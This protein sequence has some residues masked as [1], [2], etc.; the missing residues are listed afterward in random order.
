MLMTSTF[1]PVSFWLLNLKWSGLQVSSIRAS[2]SDDKRLSIFTGTKTLHLRCLSR[3]DR[4]A[5]IEALLAAKDL[6]PRVL[7]SNDLVPSEDIVVSTEKLRLRLAHEG[8]G[9]PVIKD[10]ES[11][12]LL[13][14]SELQNQLK[15]LQSKHVMLLDTLR[16][17]ETEKI[18]LET[19]VVDETKK[20]ESYCSQ[21]NRRHSEGS[22]TDSD[23]ENESQDGGDVE[24]DEDEGTYFDTY[25]ILSSYALRSAYYRSREGLRFSTQ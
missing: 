15:A 9:E 17:L 14:V 21:G 4:A 16:Q 18:E 12:M 2:K 25:D 8:V 1:L 20:R 13:E 3:E 6:F 24:T 5:W 11:I 19:T 7:S 22:G 10:C 23:A